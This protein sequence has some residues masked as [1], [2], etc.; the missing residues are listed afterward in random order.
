MAKDILT[1]VE[2]DMESLASG[3]ESETLR[4]T[5]GNTNHGAGKKKKRMSKRSR[6]KSSMHERH[7]SIN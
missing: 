2:F 6:K 5:D 1:D 4:N 3:I 7:V